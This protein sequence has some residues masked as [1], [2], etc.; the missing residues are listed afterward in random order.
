M[1]I[2]VVVADDAFLL[3]DAVASLLS[4]TPDIDPIAVVADRATLTAVIEAE[5]PDVVVT[6]IRMPPTGGDEGIAVAAELRARHPQTGVVVLSQFREPSYVLR[7][8]EGGSAGR[9]YL[10]KERVRHRGQ[11]VEAVRAVHHG[12][13]YIDPE[14]VEILVDGRARVERSPL[15]PLTRRERETLAEVATGKSNAAIAESLVLTKSAVEKHINSIFMKLDLVATPDVSS[16]VMATL[17]FLAE[18]GERAG[19]RDHLDG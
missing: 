10:L 9:A 19:R 18:A 16:R 2:R 14:I 6:D 17:M 3:R 11:L 15:A 12:G 8:F 7:L 13:S 1:P 4:E 5:H